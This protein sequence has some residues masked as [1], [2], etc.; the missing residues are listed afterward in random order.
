ME[1]A[2][3]RTIKATERGIPSACMKRGAARS[4]G[5]KL[6]SMI[7]VLALMY[8]FT[9]NSLMGAIPEWEASLAV[10]IGG[11]YALQKFWCW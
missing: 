5:E 11:R 3:D 7:M 10:S 9:L 4:I 8:A 1:Y 2:A 6:Q